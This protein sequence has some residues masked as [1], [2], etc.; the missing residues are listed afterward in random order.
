MILLSLR[1]RY[2]LRL[3]VAHFNHK[4]RRSAKDDELFSVRLAREH[5][6]S[7]YLGREDIRA[8]AARRSLNLEEAARERRYLFLKKTAARIGADR[9]ATG[10]TV[11]DQAETVLMR[12]LRGCGIRGLGGISPEVDRLIIRPLIEIERQELEAYLRAQDIPWREDES[13]RDRRF[14]RNKVRLD[15][16]PYLREGFDPRIIRHLGRLAD[17]CREED[18][19]LSRSFRRKL[20]AGLPSEH[21]GLSLDAGE[22]AGLP[23]ALAR[24][25]V[26]ELLRRLRGNLRRIS[27]GDVEAVRGLA[28]EK[29]VHLP[30]GLV[31]RRQHGR[32]LAA[33]K[34][35]QRTAL[36]YEH[37]WDGGGNL[38][39]RETGLR[40]SAA[41]LPKR[42]LRRISY[43][44]DRRAY[45]DAA[46][47][48][49]PLVVRSRKD[50]DRYRPLGAPG[51]QKL[52]E[53]M[54]AKG[55]PAAERDRHPVF[56]SGGKITWV[57]GLPVAEEFKITPAT[58]SVLCLERV[59]NS[60]RRG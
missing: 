19:Y 1:E 25:R 35:P 41:K 38:A 40:F 26:R 37:V 14:L 57:L 15:L 48:E 49:F 2:R 59:E 24:R 23:V 43:D 60:K 52:K 42:D 22:L 29:E 58:K 51:R 33:E 4:L 46:K 9:I 16:I 13:N 18:E 28:E 47:L 36:Q 50:G 6:L 56:L 30:G 8:Y 55:I 21:E 45:F 39:I 10:H 3:S 32:I 12:L 5:G 17:I 11:T 54:R 44:N 31:L 34:K 27:F 20:A 53:V 7:V